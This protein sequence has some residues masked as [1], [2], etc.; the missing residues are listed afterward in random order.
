MPLYNLV[1]RD[2]IPYETSPGYNFIW[3]KTLSTMAETLKGTDYDVFRLPKTRRL[4]DGVLDIVNAGEFT[5]S[6]ADS[7]GIYGG[8]VSSAA[9][10]QTAYRA[11]GGERYLA[12]LGSLNAL[13]EASFTSFDSLL[14][15]PIEGGS[16]STR[17]QRPRLLD[18]YGMGILNNPTDTI[19]ASMYYGYKG[20]HG[21]YDR[22]HFSVF[23]NGQPI[24]P[25]W[26][27][28]TS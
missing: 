9:V 12:E 3:V 25:I 4:Y 22:L 16:V 10:Y 8:K 18:G 24:M 11:Y 14:S 27:T 15:P 7:G 19:S 26:A 20:G 28:P 13:G 17:P 6:L 21:H 5:P 2:G 1:Y 23:A